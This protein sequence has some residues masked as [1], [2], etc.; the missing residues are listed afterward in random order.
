MSIIYFSIYY[1]HIWQY[2]FIIY[3][4]YKVLH[5]YFQYFIYYFNIIRFAM[6]IH[7][8]KY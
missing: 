1:D 8:G 5:I 7:S 4:G 3:I 2:L 6:I